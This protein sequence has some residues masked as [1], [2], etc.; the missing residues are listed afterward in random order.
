[1]QCYAIALA[2][3]FVHEDKGALECLNS[4]SFATYYL[5]ILFYAYESFVCIHVCELYACLVLGEIRRGCWVP[6]NCSYRGCDPPCGWSELNP[7]STRAKSVLNPLS[8]LSSSNIL[9]SD[10]VGTSNTVQS[11]WRE[12]FQWVL[13]CFECCGTFKC[14]IKQNCQKLQS[15]N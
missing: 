7:A 2:V 4:V 6:W 1:M 3:F 12:S 15:R 9:T 10:S 8:H 11:F 5:F 14:F 13:D